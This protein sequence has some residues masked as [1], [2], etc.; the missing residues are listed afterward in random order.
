[1]VNHIF[2]DYSRRKMFKNSEFYRRFVNCV[3]LLNK[4]LFFN[5][6]S[7]FKKLFYF[8]K[9]KNYCWVSGRRRAVY[10]AFKVSRVVM[11]GVSPPGVL[12]GMRKASW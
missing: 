5:N 4:R 8:T 2:R 9:I 12:L 3:S 11:K 10:R 6:I 7:L 1:M